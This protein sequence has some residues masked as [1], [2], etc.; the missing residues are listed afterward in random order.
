M[1]SNP[2]ARCCTIG[3][4]HDGSARGEIKKIGNTET[5]FA[6]PESKKTETA[7]LL[8]TDVIGHNFINAQLIADQFA[9]NGYYVVM[10]D[11]FEGD[12][13]PLNRPE[14]FD[15]MDWFNNSGPSKGHTFKVTDPIVE[16]V[17]NDMKTNQGVKRIGA[18][19]Y[20]FGA[21][22]VARFMT[23]GKGVDVGYMAH[24]SFVDAAE[25]KALTGPLS[26]AAAETDS[27]FPA[28]KR[29]ETEDLLKDM[30]IPYQITLYSGVEHGFAVRADIFKKH[31]KYAKEAAFVQAVAWFDEFLKNERSWAA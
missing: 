1:A 3:V 25:I 19:G 18:V 16:A 27:I 22:Y 21:K 10:P 26:I 13:I 8:L 17:I 20:C 28:E 31:V 30:S 9:A 15:L 2:S 24:P 5:Y 12:P 23:G 7:I 11:L 29:R 14:G 6:Y 4:T